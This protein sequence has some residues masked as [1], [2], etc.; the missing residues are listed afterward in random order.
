MISISIIGS[1]NLA[2]HLIKAFEHSSEVELKQVAVRKKS[3]DLPIGGYK[4]IDDLTQLQK[5][6]V[7]IIAV[8]DHAIENISELLTF[9]NTLVVHTSGGT[10]IDVL[11]NQN[12]KGVFYPLQTFSKSKPIRF[13]EIP[14]CIEAENDN[15]YVILEKLGLSISKKIN[16]IDSEQRKS[17]HIAAVFVS[18]FTNHLYKIGSDICLEHNLPFDILIP[19]ITE[20]ADKIKY[21]DPTAAQTGPAKRQDFQTIAQHMKFLKKSDKKHLYET[22]TQSIIQNG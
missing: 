13:D 14:I 1:G 21:L 8:S 17:L 18:N 9:K 3:Y 4:I 20:T 10:S 11:N 5:T 7:T 2:Y 12:R 15:D 6:D 19:L 22:L 16:K